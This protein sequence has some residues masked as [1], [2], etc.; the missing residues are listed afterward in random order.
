MFKAWLLRSQFELNIKTDKNTYKLE[1]EQAS[2]EE[3]IEFYLTIENEHILVWLYK[4]IEDNTTESSHWIRDC[5]SKKEF[6]DMWEE[7]I[8]KLLE[9]IRN[10]R[11][12]VP[13]VRGW[14]GK[15]APFESFI[16]FLSEK[17]SVPP[18]ILIKEYTFEQAVLFARWVEYN[19][20]MQSPEGE[21]RNAQNEAWDTIADGGESELDLVRKLRDLKNNKYSNA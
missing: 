13:K 15:D 3:T 19:V 17:C 8:E 6:L 21:A 18:H 7:N 1:Y 16:A 9:N 2:I 5:M 20:N 11:F 14:G 10:T 12:R 4:F